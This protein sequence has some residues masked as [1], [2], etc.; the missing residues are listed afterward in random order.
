M[1][2]SCGC[3]VSAFF[4][5]LVAHFRKNRIFGFPV[6]NLF[7]YDSEFGLRYHPTSGRSAELRKDSSGADLS[8]LRVLDGADFVFG[9]FMDT[10]RVKSLFSIEP[11]RHFDSSTG[12]D[13]ELNKKSST[14]HGLDLIFPFVQT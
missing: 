7:C 14:F 13:E 6:G 5:S 3:H 1:S 8:L 11:Q 9:D 4:C 2:L 12:E 10:L